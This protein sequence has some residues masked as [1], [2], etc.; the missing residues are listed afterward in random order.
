MGPKRKKAS[1]ARYLVKG[2]YRGPDDAVYDWLV[3]ERGQIPEQLK[4]HLNL[5][6]VS[7]SD[8]VYGVRPTRDG[9]LHVRDFNR[10]YAS[11]YSDQIED[12]YRYLGLP[13]WFRKFNG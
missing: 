5:V 10:S 1:P 8:S 11:I 13:A 9:I 4:S 3:E 7:A 12:H 6:E 2:G